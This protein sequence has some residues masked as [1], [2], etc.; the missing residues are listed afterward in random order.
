MLLVDMINIPFVFDREILHR[1]VPSIPCVVTQNSLLTLLRQT[2][3]REYKIAFSLE[4]I[5][6]EPVRLLAI[7]SLG[8]DN[9]NPSDCIAMNELEKASVALLCVRTSPVPFDKLKLN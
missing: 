2:F 9:L 8:V 1:V 7:I 4:E 5:D 6:N 3:E